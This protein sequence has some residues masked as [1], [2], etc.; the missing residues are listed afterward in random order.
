[1]TE[2][3][4]GPFF[5]FFEGDTEANSNGDVPPRLFRAVSACMVGIEESSARSV[6]VFVEHM[7]G[8]TL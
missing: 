8:S 7:T 4:P 2:L 3:K 1:M 5:D 6:W